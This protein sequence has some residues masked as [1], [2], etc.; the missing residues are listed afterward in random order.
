MPQ[1]RHGRHGAHVRDQARRQLRACRRCRP[2][3]EGARADRIAIP[4]ASAESDGTSI[5][6]V[7]NATG[8]QTE[9]TLNVPVGAKPTSRNGAAI[10]VASKQI[11]NVKPFTVDWRVKEEAIP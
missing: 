7:K 2:G 3:S 5:A 11:P 6:T 10:M 1:P 9:V 4:A 8:E